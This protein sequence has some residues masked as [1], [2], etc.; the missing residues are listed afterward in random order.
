MPDIQPTRSE[1]IV[2]KKRIILAKSGHMLLKK[3]RDGLIKEFFEVLEKAKTARR[4][5]RQAYVRARKKGNVMRALHSNLELETLSLAILP[6][7]D[8]S[9]GTKNIMGTVVPTIT[10][11]GMQKKL[12]E[13]G[14]GL[15]TTS[16]A[17]N[18]TCAAYEKLVEQILTVAEVET[19]TRRLIDEIGKTKRRVNA[20]EHELIPRMVKTKDRIILRLD[21]I[22]RETTFRVKM[23]KRKLEQ[24]KE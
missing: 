13:R 17:V 24:R 8:I 18:E 20:L 4:D 7:P 5:L 16:N 9:I 10:S 22:E 14:Y 3:K 1:L 2:L 12:S 11:E 23:T 15:L 19:T 21:E 6:A